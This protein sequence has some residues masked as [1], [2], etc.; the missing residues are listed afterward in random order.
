MHESEKWKWSR[1]VVY[2]SNAWK[3]KMKVKSLSRVRLLTTPWTAAH[4]GPSSLGFFRHKSAGVGCH[5][6][7]LLS[8]FS[9]VRL[10]ATPETAA[11]QAPPSLGLL[12]FCNFSLKRLWEV[13]VCSRNLYYLT[14]QEIR[15]SFLTLVSVS[16]MPWSLSDLRA[17]TMFS[18][19]CIPNARPGAQHKV[20]TW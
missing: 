3:W 19:F 8:H 10:C 12:P 7:L 20:G 13:C 1:S 15:T 6:L 16:I 11:H 5:C 2:D 14:T 18:W 17:G 9:R 4:Q